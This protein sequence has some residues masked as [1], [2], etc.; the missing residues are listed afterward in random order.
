MG[1]VI[2][3]AK[4]GKPAGRINIITAPV[5]EEKPEPA[6]VTYTVV[7]GDCLWII[8]E[9][10]LGDGRRYIE[11]YELNKDIIKNPNLIYISQVLKI[12]AK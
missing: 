12:P 8:A 1:G 2:S 5:V 9:K 4:Y 3:E 10:Y 7:K 6:V 11:I